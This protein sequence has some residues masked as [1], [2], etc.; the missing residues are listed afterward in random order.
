MSEKKKVLFVCLG[1][2]WFNQKSLR[3]KSCENKSPF[4]SDTWLVFFIDPLITLNIIGNICRSP[5]AEAVFIDVVS[6]QGL[7]DKFEVDS[8]A[9]GSWHVG[10][11][12][13][14]RAQD[15]MKKHSL[16]Y[17]NTARQVH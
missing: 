12:P 5:I 13:E 6:K 16:A 1:M 8:A 14:H 15:T 11:R 4:E 17:S 9:I 2:Y 7:S 3:D 10:R